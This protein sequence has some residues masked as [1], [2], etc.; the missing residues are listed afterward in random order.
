M[1]NE[2]RED[3]MTP[4]LLLYLAGVGIVLWLARQ[5]QKQDAQAQ[6]APGAPLPD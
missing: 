3:G 6:E 4:R 5:V 2:R 1:A